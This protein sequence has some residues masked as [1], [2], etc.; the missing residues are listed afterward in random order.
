MEAAL[1]DQGIE[2]SATALHN[3]SKESSRKGDILERLRRRLKMKRSKSPDPE[4]ST[5]KRTVPNNS[6]QFLSIGP[7]MRN[8]GTALWA[9]KT[10]E[11]QETQ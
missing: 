7:I 11:G 6:D 1:R 9:N 10:M 8:R 4:P 2:I 5:S 3:I